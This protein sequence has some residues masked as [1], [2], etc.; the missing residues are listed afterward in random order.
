MGFWKPDGVP[1]WLEGLSPRF[2]KGMGET[3]RG[4]VLGL[5]SIE[6]WGE[7]KRPLQVG[8]LGV[9][10]KGGVGNRELRR[11]SS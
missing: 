8:V 5:I 7:A 3:Q 4:F 2:L 9:C 11:S 10:F 6:S 1:K